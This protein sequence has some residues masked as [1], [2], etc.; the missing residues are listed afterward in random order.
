[1]LVSDFVDAVGP[2]GSGIECLSGGIVGHVWTGEAD[3]SLN[4][5]SEE[6]MD[7]SEV[8]VGEGVGLDFSRGPGGSLVLDLLN[9]VRVDWVVE[10]EG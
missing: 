6:S 9:D 1:M 2:L 8:V 4:D 5:G 10:C 3:G 7:L